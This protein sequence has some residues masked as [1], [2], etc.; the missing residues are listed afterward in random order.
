M[1]KISDYLRKLKLRFSRQKMKV[2][3]EN[4]V[5]SLFTSLKIFDKIEKGEI[6][7]SNCNGTITIENFGFLTY[8]GG[9]IHLICNKLDCIHKNT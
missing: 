1:K 6:K 2:V 7:C 8:K 4:D 5:I 9:S 3:H